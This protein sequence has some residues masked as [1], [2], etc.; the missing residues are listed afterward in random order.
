MLSY[1]AANGVVG[2]K[3]GVLGWV[4]TPRGTDICLEKGF[5]SEADFIINLSHNK[6]KPSCLSIFICFLWWQSRLLALLWY[7]NYDKLRGFILSLFV[8]WIGCFL[9]FELKAWNIYFLYNVCLEIHWWGLKRL[10][11][12]CPE[13]VTAASEIHL[14]DFFL[15]I[16]FYL[17]FIFNGFYLMYIV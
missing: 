10:L 11:V 7:I 12:W 15:N 1:T 9:G 5:P 14:S 8:N 4:E 16:Y 17:N 3:K 2:V 13:I 6:F